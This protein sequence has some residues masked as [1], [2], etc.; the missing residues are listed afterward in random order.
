MQNALVPA[1]RG[2]KLQT[3]IFIMYPQPAAATCKTFIAFVFTLQENHHHVSDQQ[4]LNDLKNV[5]TKTGGKP[6]SARKYAERG[7]FSI[8]TVCRRFGTWNKAL[9]R[10]GLC[11]VRKHKTDDAELIKNLEAVWRQLGRQPRYQEMRKPLS[12]FS[13]KPYVRRF[14]TFGNAL[15]WFAASKNKGG[16]YGTTLEKK[17]KLCGALQ[18]PVFKHK[19]SRIPSERLKVRVLMRDGNK[20]RIC[21]KTLTEGDIHFDHIIPWSRGG[22]TVLENLQVLCKKHNCAKGNR[23]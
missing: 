7:I 18:K 21:G 8:D 22:E 11:P 23:V 4:V 10:A 1:M 13:A 3:R 19:T 15:A 2:A 20:C 9:E 6:V 17:D 16:R 5:W 14:K 12:K